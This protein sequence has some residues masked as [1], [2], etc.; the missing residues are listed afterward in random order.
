MTLDEYRDKTGISDAEL[1]RRVG[2]HRSRIHRYRTGQEF[3]SFRVMA[4]IEKVTGGKV[5]FADLAKAQ[6]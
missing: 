2:V 5:R 6:K 1:G 3:P 4:M